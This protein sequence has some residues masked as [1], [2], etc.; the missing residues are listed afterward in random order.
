MDQ[1]DAKVLSGFRPSAH[2][3]RETARLRDTPHER[4]GNDSGLHE[5]E[6]QVGE[7][8]IET[9]GKRQA[10]DEA[11]IELL[12]TT[13]SPAH[14]RHSGRIAAMDEFPEPGRENS[15]EMHEDGHRASPR[16]TKCMGYGQLGIERC[17][18]SGVCCN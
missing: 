7:Y 6:R 14:L 11:V 13:W 16:R 12:H 9:G 1:S 18:L 8:E 10:R 3:D 15:L 2:Q 5:L 17:K 4:R